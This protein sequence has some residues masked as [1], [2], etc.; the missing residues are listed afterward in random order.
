MLQTENYQQVNFYSQFRFVVSFHLHSNE[1]VRVFLIHVK[2]N[3]LVYFEDCLSVQRM[4]FS[5]AK[6]NMLKK[7]KCFNVS[8]KCIQRK[9]VHINKTLFDLE[10]VEDSSFQWHFSHSGCHYFD[11]Y[12]VVCM[13]FF[14]LVGEPV[15]ESKKNSSST[16]KDEIK[17][18]C[19]NFS[20][21][22]KFIIRTTYN[23]VHSYYVVHCIAYSW[24]R[25]SLPLIIVAFCLLC[26]LTISKQWISSNVGVGLVRFVFECVELKIQVITWSCQVLC[27]QVSN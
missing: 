2:F 6:K 10:L 7:W 18:K 9:S 1:F 5:Y 24:S 14:W 26:L 3:D 20:C 8:K 19:F 22:I 13:F 17:W 21:K 25:S 15:P 4:N 23:V 27:I 16:L 12:F 11:V